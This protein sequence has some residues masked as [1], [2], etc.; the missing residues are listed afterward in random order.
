IGSRYQ[1]QYQLGEGGF[2]R[3]YLAKDTHRFSELCVLKEFAPYVDGE[4]ALQKAETLFEREAGVLYQLQHPQIPTFRELLRANFERRERLFLVQDYVDGQTYQHLLEE[5]QEQGKIFTEEEVQQFLLDILP[6]LEYIHS[7]DVIHRDISPDNLIKRASD[8]LP[9]LIDFGGVKQVAT[10]ISRPA[11]VTLVGKVGFAPYEQIQHGQTYPHS[12]LYALAATA[13]VLF[14]GESAPTLFGSRASSTW[15]QRVNLSPRLTVVLEK[16]LA[17][18]PRDRFQTAKQV[19]VA[20]S[21]QNSFPRHH[22][23][24]STGPRDTSRGGRSARSSPISTPP[25]SVSQESDRGWSSLLLVLLAIAAIGLSL[26]IGYRLLPQTGTDAGGL[27]GTGEEAQPPDLAT[28]RTQLG[29][30]SRFLVTLTDQ[31]FYARYPDQQGRSLTDSAEDEPWR[32]RWQE[33]AHD[34]LTLLETNL[35]PQARQGLGSYSAADLERWTKAANNLYVGRAALTDLTDALFFHVF[36]QQRSQSIFDQPL[37]QIWYAMAL[38]QLADMQSGDTLFTLNFPGGSYRDEANG[39]LAPGRGH[40]YVMELTQGQLLRLNLQATRGQTRLSLY[41]PVPTAEQPSLLERSRQLTWSGRLPQT[42]FYEVVI[43]STVAD[44]TA[45]RLNV[46]AD[47]V[48]Q[49]APSPAEPAPDSAGEGAATEPPAP[50]LEPDLAPVESGAD[51]SEGEEEASNQ[52]DGEDGGD[53]DA[54]DE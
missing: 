39:L 45:Y 25:P 48:S 21:P 7:V 52:E 19:R 5:R 49:P 27:F 29:V 30:D 20:L 2:G 37:G 6:V 33:I 47:V 3:T 18:N 26:F 42:G 53:E 36:P 35:S 28:R 1:L 15:L 32:R 4:S 8:G 10:S 12:D 9:V 40:V 11:A 23:V 13:L 43:T 41:P 24:G 17:E 14:T 46:S 34:W 31:T 51:P 50:P 22:R 38:D 54:G 44:T 16:M